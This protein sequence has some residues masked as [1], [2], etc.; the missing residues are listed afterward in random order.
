MYFYYYLY[1]YDFKL[2]WQQYAVK[3]SDTISYISVELVE[4]DMS[5]TIF[6]LTQHIKRNNFTV[7]FILL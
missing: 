7:L 4:S 5:D 6:T 3:Y 2:S 1:L